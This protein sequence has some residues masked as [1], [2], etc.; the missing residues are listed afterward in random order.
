MWRMHLWTLMF[1]AVLVQALPAVAGFP[2]CEPLANNPP[3]N[4]NA[5]GKYPADPAIP[6]AGS[7]TKWTRDGVEIKLSINGGTASQFIIK[8]VNYEPTQIG[9]AASFPPFNDFFYQNS[10]D[11]WNPLWDRDIKTLRAIGVNSIRTYGVWKWEP[12]FNKGVPPHNGQPVQDGVAD[13]WP[14]LNFSATKASENDNQFCD[15]DD[16]SAYT[17]QHTTHEPFLDRLWNNGKNPIYVWLGLSVPLDLVDPNVSAARKANLRQFYRYTAK[18]MAK[19]YGNHPAVIGFVIG[20][21]IDTPATTPTSEFWQTL[22]DLNEVIK[23]SA[24]DKLTAVTFHDTPDYNRTITSGSFKGKRGPQ[25][26]EPDVWGFN[27]YTNP[28]P[29]GNL[30]SRFRDDVVLVCEK[31]GS[32]CQ[33]K[34]LMYGEFGTPADTH[35]A[36]PNRAKAYP[37]EWVAENFVWQSAPPP[38]RCLA[39]GDLGPPPGSGGDGPNAEALAKKTIA[40]EMAAGKDP[41]TL[42]ATLAADFAGSGL[43]AG[44]PL[45]AQAQADWLASFW[46]VHLKHIASNGAERDNL[47]LYSSGGYAFE[48]RDEW[49]KGNETYPYFHSV[50]GNQQC[51]TSWKDCPNA[52]ANTGAANV[53]FP[54]GWGDEEWFGLTGAKANG[55]ADN[56]PVINTSTGTLNGGPDILQP[57]A[58]V[59]ALC[60]LFRPN[61]QCP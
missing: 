61:Q 20:N 29:E 27:P 12:G 23:A 59:A 52:C 5:N 45:A 16:R 9:G 8:G 13:F 15:P 53:V 50:S 33:A 10:V 14:L 6:Y 54:G 37:L 4:P 7:H 21:E 30:Y 47:M 43:K 32:G 51:G 46:A 17:F 57:R 36:S 39:V 34:P 25:V 19:K 58:A 44:S 56:A 2:S 40:I 26:Y 28:A 41:Y 49:W 55:R 3:L 11:T 24:P 60:Q 48:W 42:P 1:L 18:W 22:N 38:A 31:A 35:Q